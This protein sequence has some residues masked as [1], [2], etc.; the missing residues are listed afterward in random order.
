MMR[1]SAIP[2]SHSSC[3]QCDKLATAQSLPLNLLMGHCHP[4]LPLIAC[5]PSCK[6]WSRTFTE[7]MLQDGATC[8][9][10]S[11]LKGCLS[12]V[13]AQAEQTP[14]AVRDPVTAAKLKCAGALAALEAKK[15]KTA[16]KRF[17]EA[18]PGCQPQTCPSLPQNI[19]I[20]TLLKTLCW[21][22][23]ST[24]DRGQIVHRGAPL[25]PYAALMGS[26]PEDL[27]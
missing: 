12:G 21:R 9:R 20:N 1:C 15:Y 25:P 7:V 19:L 3:V 22:P 23:R 17:T 6:A 14:D 8:S 24:E 18:R 5:D 13:G 10:Y 27:D 11:T 2:H 26:V 16:A 4:S